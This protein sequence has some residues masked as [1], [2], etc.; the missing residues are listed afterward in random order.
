MFK[1]SGIQIF[2]S[3]ITWKSIIYIKNLIF[4]HKYLYN[5]NILLKSLDSFFHHESWKGVYLWLLDQTNWRFGKGLVLGSSLKRRSKKLK[6]YKLK[7]FKF[8]NDLCEIKTDSL[9]DSLLECTTHCFKQLR[10][11]R[12]AF[13][14]TQNQLGLQRLE[15]LLKFL[16]GIFNT[17]A[18]K[19]C[20]PFQ[21][22]LVHELN[23]ILKAS[24][25]EWFE[26]TVNKH[27]HNVSQLF[28][29]IWSNFFGFNWVLI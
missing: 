26:Q 29:L 6:I 15:C 1:N 3:K 20:F 14:I 13:P 24:V 21:N 19:Y 23:T 27:F 25:A 22:T 16:F 5:L 8:T 7:I 9:R 28:E 4:D 11:M 10:S 18:Y 2:W 17:N 12:K